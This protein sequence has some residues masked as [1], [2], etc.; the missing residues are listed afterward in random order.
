M[1]MDVYGKNPK[2]ER[3]AYFRNNVWWWHPLAEF[4]EENY[5]EIAE[6]CEDWHSNSGYGLGSR[7]SVTLAK[8]II[9][10]IERGMV[11]EWQDRY[12][13]KLAELPRTDCALCGATGI[14][15]DDKG[16]RLGYHD[17]ALS[18][19]EAIVL[20]RATG[21]C[22]GCEGVGTTAH[23]ACNYPF[24]V[25]NVQEFA[26]FLLECGGFRIH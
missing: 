25:D 11:D 1:G 17:K 24:S 26:E 21:W 12:R 4:I 22:N 7:D 5:P 13:K 20:G 9:A 10:D 15:T 18:E 2:S 23:W 14:R 8:A 3:G 19:T 6:K 16:L